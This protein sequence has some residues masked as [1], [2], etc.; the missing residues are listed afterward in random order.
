MYLKEVLTVSNSFSPF[1][2][3]N[4]V[5]LSILV[6]RRTVVQQPAILQFLMDRMYWEVHPCLQ[7][8]R[9][10]YESSLG[11]FELVEIDGWAIFIAFAPFGCD[12]RQLK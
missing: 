10:V 6:H 2:W 4:N 7:A 1:V 11:V 5:F 8:L 12:A 3:V 9:R